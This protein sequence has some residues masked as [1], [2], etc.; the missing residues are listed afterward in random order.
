M[1]RVIYVIVCVLVL[2]FTTNSTGSC[3]P[4]SGQPFIDVGLW[5]KQQNI[6]VSSRGDFVVSNESGKTLY[7][8]S[9]NEKVSI[10]YT[11]GGI[12]INGKK[13]SPPQIVVMLKDTK[14]DCG[15]DVNRRSYRGTIIIKTATRLANGLTVINSLPVESYLYGVVAN[16]ISPEWPSDAIKAQAI[17]AR[18]Y[19]L[20]S[21]NKHKADGYDVCTSTDC[22]VYGGISSESNQTTKA[23]NE[24]RGMVINHYF[25][26]PLLSAS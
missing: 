4:S 11:D 22:Q 26:L 16:E 2:I 9:A 3:V 10:S 8:F 1:K 5:T 7:N 13:I 25:A 19:A 20:Y 18:T 12:A 15:I 17:A 6:I 14:S 21:I 24:T 23:V